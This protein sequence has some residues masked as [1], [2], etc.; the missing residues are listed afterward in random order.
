M[1]FFRTCVSLGTVWKMISLFLGVE[2]PKVT[3]HMAQE[4]SSLLAYQDFHL[5]RHYSW[6][7][8]AAV[9]HIARLDA[10]TLS[11]WGGRHC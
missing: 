10:A 6:S 1:N 11:A 4:I 2:P 9:S 8:G 3:H 7:A 5:L